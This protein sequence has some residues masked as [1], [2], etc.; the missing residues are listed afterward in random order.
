[1]VFHFDLV[2]IFCITLARLCKMHASI[3]LDEELKSTQPSKHTTLIQRI[4][5]EFTLNRRLYMLGKLLLFYYFSSKIYGLGT[6]LK[7]IT[8]AHLINSYSVCFL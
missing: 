5:G 3:T 8:E 6:H 2:K 4:D 7:H 1:M